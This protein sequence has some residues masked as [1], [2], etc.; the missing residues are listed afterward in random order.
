VEEYMMRADLRDAK[1]SGIGIEQARAA[2]LEVD[3]WE[4]TPELVVCSPLSRAIA[5][6]S[7]FHSFADPADF[8]NSSIPR[9]GETTCSLSVLNGYLHTT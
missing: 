5:T 3:M 2:G 4:T 8:F 7:D 9:R 6:A 1:L